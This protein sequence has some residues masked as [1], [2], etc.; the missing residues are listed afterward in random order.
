M[1][2]EQ[3]SK[4]HVLSVK[5]LGVAFK[6]DEGIVRGVNDVSF[7]VPKGKTLGIVGESGSGKTVASQAIMQL[8]P[9]NGYIDEASE[10]TLE[11]NGQSINITS[12]KADSREMRSIRGGSISMIFQ[13]P[14]ASFSPVYTIG[15]QMEESILLHRNVSKD[16]AREIALDMLDRVGIANPSVRLEQYS[17]ELSGGMR[18][19][20]MIAMALA[21]EPL[22]LIADEPTTALDVTIQAQILELMRQLQDDLHMSIIFITHDLGVIAQIAH[23]VVVMYLGQVMER[24]TTREIIKESAHPYTI[25]L[26][27]A[28]PKLDLLSDRLIPISGD[29]PSPLARPPGCP[30]HTRCPEFIP[31]KCEISDP[32]ETKLS[33]THYVSCFLHEGEGQNDG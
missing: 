30:F 1:M 8:L 10:I 26:L 11:R 16:E 19:R 12:L 27:N 20:A 31:E 33:E 13:E 5:K 22:L 15:N 28:I 21:T 14:M 17:F 9:K 4:Q 7:E 24:G 18:Q 29:I 3:F 25:S 32:E 6:T 23:E 2:T